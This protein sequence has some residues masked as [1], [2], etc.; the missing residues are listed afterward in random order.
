[1]ARSVIDVEHIGLAGPFW[2]RVFDPAMWSAPLAG[3]F[4]TNRSG[5][6]L[7]LALPH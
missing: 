7:L 1:M 6:M 2:I 5:A 3:N 4:D